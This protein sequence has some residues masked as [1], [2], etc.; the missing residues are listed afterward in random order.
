MLNSTVLRVKDV[1]FVGI[2]PDKYQ[3]NICVGNISKDNEETIK[4]LT[5][6]RGNLIEL[7]EVKK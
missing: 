3:V 6:F 4:F 5:K 7:R 1:L 2:G